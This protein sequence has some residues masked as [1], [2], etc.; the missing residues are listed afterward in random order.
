[1]FVVN[2]FL[3]GNRMGKRSTKG[4]GRR[5]SLFVSSES[6]PNPARA[7]PQVQTPPGEKRCRAYTR[8]PART[9]NSGRFPGIGEKVMQEHSEIR[10]LHHFL[11]D[12][13]GDW[14]EMPEGNRRYVM[15][16]SRK[17]GLGHHFFT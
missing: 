1:M 11:R 13:R 6:G 4:G 8:D 12:R 3:S 10:F 14:D 16:G 5:A 15:P 9:S 7:P 2:S 17:Q